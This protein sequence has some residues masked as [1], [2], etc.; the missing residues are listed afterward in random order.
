M[1]TQSELESRVRLALDKLARGSPTAFDVARY[2]RAFHPSARSKAKS[3][4]EAL[5]RQD[6]PFRDLKPVF[7]SVGGADGEELGYLLANTEAQTGILIEKS[8]ELAQAARQRSLP[9]GKNIEV[10][11]GDATEIIGDAI[12]HSSDL[13]K[14]HKAG[15]QVVTCH[16][17]IHELYD[18]TRAGFNPLT[19]FGRIFADQSI[20]TWFT[21]REP[22]APEKWPRQVLI[23]SGC[24][25]TVLLELSNVLR[26]KHRALADLEPK[27]QVIGDHL[28]AHKDV[29]MELIV[30]LFYLDD[31]GYELQERST[32]VNHQHM[33]SSLLFAVSDTAVS[34]KRAEV[35]S[36]SSATE[37]FRDLWREWGIKVVGLNSED[38]SHFGLAVPESQTRVIAWRSPVSASIPEGPRGSKHGDLPSELEVAFDAFSSGDSDLLQALLVSKGRRWIEQDHRDQAL[39][40]VRTAMAR[41]P[42]DSLIHLWC[43]YL[44][45]L[46]EL[47]SGR[48][49]SP[50]LFSEERRKEAAPHGLDTLF[51]A[52]SMEFA[53]KTGAGQLPVAVANQLA[54]RLVTLDRA[55][56]TDYSPLRR[57]AIGT[58]FFVFANLLRS[59]GLYTAA[60]E[61]LTKTETWLMAGIDS[62]D[63][64]RL[65]CFYA[66]SVCG[67]VQG[68]VSFQAPF[69]R[70]SDVSERFAGALIQLTYSFAA[71]FV[72]DLGRA[73][74]YASQAAA[75]FETIGAVNYRMRALTVG[76]LLH[77]WHDLQ[78]GQEPQV[79]A[80]DRDL[81]KGLLFLAG[82]NNEASWF[83]DWFKGLRPSK[84]AGL[85]QFRHFSKNERIVHDGIDVPVLLHF[86][87]DSRLEWQTNRVG[88]LDE[89]ET[90]LRRHLGAPERNRIPLLAD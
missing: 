60:L 82:R 20:P 56:P 61:N 69:E 80:L 68:S 37:S 32:S 15:Y 3:V 81:A 1:T 13:V 86:D 35:S 33:M 58:S 67:G 65:H 66:K 78:A 40:L 25:P 28:L 59:G 49:P 18:R 72:D 19:F 48:S 83:K 75:M 76:A 30:K 2:G 84:A 73:E 27:P 5:G 34:E 4:I 54:E 46:S 41:Y 77:A 9:D 8:R 36:S 88:S 57:Y 17:V 70:L 74:Q 85:L 21:Y 71:W 16:A 43:H 24:G 45:S 23:Q 79:G 39:E 44:V 52:E 12:N 87:K 22:G 50:T 63:T 6:N 55:T 64:E 11:E 47:F 7:I 62:H 14:S 53:R 89:A 38:G 42:V 31:L 29:A 90:I 10:F 26:S 51:L